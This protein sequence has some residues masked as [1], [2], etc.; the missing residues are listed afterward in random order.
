VEGISVTSGNK[1][2]KKGAGRR[3]RRIMSH[4][5]LKKDRKEEKRQIDG[6]N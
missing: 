1:E 6:Q 3:E 4:V 2:G 5:K